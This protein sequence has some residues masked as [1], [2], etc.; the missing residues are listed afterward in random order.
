LSTLINAGLPF[1]TSFGT[2]IEQTE[3]KKFKQVLS[4]VKK[5]VEGGS[6]FAESLA[7]HPDVFS[8]LYVNMIRA[9]ET[10]GV[11]EE[12]LSRLA[13]LAE[14]E[15]ETRARVKAATRYPLI[16]VFAVVAAFIV[17]I[18]LVVPRFSKIYANF[19]AVLPLPTR[20]L[21][22]ISDAIQNYWPFL[23]GA[24]ILIV[25][26]IRQFVRSEPGRFFWDRVKLKIPVFGPILLKVTMSRL[27][28]MFGTLI[29]SGLPLIQ[30]LEIV[31]STVG[32]VTIQ[33]VVENVRDS[34][35]EGKG[36]VQ[37]MR[38][39]KAFP[40]LV[41][42][43]VAVGEETGRLEEMLVKVS[44]Y[45]DVEVEYAIRNL[46]TALE[47]ILLLIIGGMVLFLAL[48]IFLPWW[49]LVSVFHQ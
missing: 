38:S 9:G 34:A 27:T 4:K 43:M 17:L 11:L 23:V 14:H 10:G 40:P 44:E 35:R 19:H 36:I 20:I 2:L 42:Q 3:N 30:T 18:T 33:R 1:V 21:I 37:P 5:D 24:V 6:T 7:R 16:V 41:L 45:Y 26:G 39:S 15:A 29:R 49:N 13:W 8:T 31:A 48:G 32:N 25:L 47:P 22:G 12:I 28:R 46:S